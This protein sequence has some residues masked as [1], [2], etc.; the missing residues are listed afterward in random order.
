MD[1][2]LANVAV[3]GLGFALLN[4]VITTEKQLRDPNRSKP[5]KI[6]VAVGTAVLML[7]AI[8]IGGLALSSL[9]GS[10]ELTVGG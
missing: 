5:I 8:G 7:Y 9:F 3:W 10:T 2:I 1:V 6:V 4:L